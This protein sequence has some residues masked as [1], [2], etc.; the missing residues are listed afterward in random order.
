MANANSVNTKNINDVAG[1][2][3][4]T[5]FDGFYDNRYYDPMV[6]GYGFIFVT[7]PSLY[8]TPDEIDTIAYRNMTRDT[9]FKKF[10]DTNSLN[11]S[12]RLLPKILSFHNYNN[13]RTFIPMFTNKLKNLEASDI[14]MESSDAFDT[15]QGYRMPLPTSYS[16]S[17]ATSQLSLSVTESSNLDFTKLMSLWVKYI[18]NISDGTFTANAE[19]IRD[20]I[21]DYMC[22]IYY[23]ALAPDGRTIKYWCKY[24]GCWPTTIPYSAMRYNKG[25]PQLVDLDIPF[26]YTYKEDMSVDVLQDFNIVS[27]GIY[28]GDLDKSGDIDKYL[29]LED[30][31]KDYNEYLHAADRQPLVIKEDRANGEKAYI[32]SFGSNTNTN[33]FLRSVMRNTDVTVTSLINNEEEVVDT[34]NYFFSIDADDGFFK[35]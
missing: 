3:N 32:L 18:S 13:T 7:K 31:D 34:D 4:L 11:E 22:S 24:S 6:S 19:C 12:D 21:I 27:L 35:L 33:S 2:D 9:Y 23:I 29:T 1:Y 10:T 30:L 28:D 20:G 8:I 15:K 26:I 16:A 25:D 17:E 5:T 14:V